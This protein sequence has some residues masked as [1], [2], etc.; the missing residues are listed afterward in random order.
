ML[1][2]N[3]SEMCVCVCGSKVFRIL[4][5]QFMMVRICLVCLDYLCC[6]V[7]LY[8][9]G[10]QSLKPSKCVWGLW[11]HMRVSV[12]EKVR[13]VWVWEAAFVFCLNLI[14]RWLMTCAGLSKRVDKRMDHTRF[15]LSQHEWCALI[16]LHLY[17]C[18]FLL[19]TVHTRERFHV[20]RD[21]EHVQSTAIISR[22][23]KL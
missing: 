3:D 19:S 21:A 23:R 22:V 8:V 13:L 16:C 14:K 17:I 15:M 6:Y 12:F 5:S 9:F 18:F 10:L 1:S 7:K 20:S 4:K 11:A 2:L